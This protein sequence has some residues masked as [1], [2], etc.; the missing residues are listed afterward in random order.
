MM[1][2]MA[3]IGI[4]FLIDDGSPREPDHRM[5]L[6]LRLFSLFNH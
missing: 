4:F 2:V 5:A 6:L 1:Q 3:C